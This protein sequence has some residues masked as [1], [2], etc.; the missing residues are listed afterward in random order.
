MGLGTSFKKRGKGEKKNGGKE[1]REK[2]NWGK[3]EKG[4]RVKR[5]TLG[6]AEWWLHVWW[7]STQIAPLIITTW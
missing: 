5:E 6:K 2:K 7:G 1:K 3:E 4:K